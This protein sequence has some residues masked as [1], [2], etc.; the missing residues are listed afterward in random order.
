[1]NVRLA[2]RADVAVVAE[3]LDEATRWVGERGFEQWPLP[4]PRD[5]LVASIDRGEVHVVEEDG[6]PVAT[7][8]LYYED[9]R[10]WGDRPP[11]AVYVHKLAVRRDRAGLG[12][13]AA[14]IDWAAATARAAER[15]FVRLDCLA[16]NPGIRGYYEQLGFE[17][18]GELVLGGRNMSLY[19]RRVHRHGN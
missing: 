10:Y 1:M 6:E 17:H 13:G 5:Q 19:E 15:Q 3:L 18:C 2:R 12:L 8:T 11:D 9:P 7:V 4:F 16:D 14:I